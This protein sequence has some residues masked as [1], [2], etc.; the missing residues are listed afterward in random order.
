[1]KNKKLAIIGGMGPLA[2]KV[3]YE[4]TIKNTVASKDQEHI[5]IIILNHATM[6]DR[7]EAILEGRESHFLETIKKDFELLEKTD[8]SN[9][10]IPCNTSHYFYK[11][12]QEI[13][14]IN[15]IN[16]IEKT[17]NHIYNQ[18]GEGSKVAILAT[19]GTISTGIYKDE[20]LIHQLI[21]YHL[22]ELNQKNVM[23]II[24]NI[25]ADVDYKPEELE[26]IITHLVTKEHCSCVILGCTELSSVKLKKEIKQ[27]CVDPLEILVDISI[28]L[29]GK[30]SKLNIR[31]SVL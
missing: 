30:E 27:Y 19:D 26:D 10:A 4:K 28:K 14:T 11:Q 5:D 22:D 16:M 17:A 1:M 7:T 12:M 24:Y 20:C 6:P 23:E 31:E 15:I 29:S 13:T 18:Y 25:K 3:F 8:V 2:T 21:P 9:I